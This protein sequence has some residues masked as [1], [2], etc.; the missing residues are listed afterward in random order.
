MVQQQFCLYRDIFG[1]PGQ[2]LHSFRI[3]NIAVIDV[4]ATL[5][6]ALLLT[7]LT[8]RTVTTFLII[9]VILFIL[10]IILHHIFCVQTTIEQM[11]FGS[12]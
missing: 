7:F 9:S 4:L 6:V 12:I 2:G 10:G 3:A 8:T 5:L 1:K 11:I